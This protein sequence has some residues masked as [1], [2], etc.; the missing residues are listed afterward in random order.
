MSTQVFLELTQILDFELFIN[1]GLTQSMDIKTYVNPKKPLS[2]YV[3]FEL[4]QVLDLQLFINIAKVQ[5]MDMKTY[6]NS[7]KTY[8]N[9]DF[10]R[11]DVGWVLVLYFQLFLGIGQA[12]D[13]DIKAYVH[14]QKT[15]I[16]IGFGFS[17]DY[18]CMTG[19]RCEYQNLG[20]FQ[21]TYI[22]RGFLGIDISFN[23]LLTY[24]AK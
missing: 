4:A 16:D 24:I 22:N 5:G 17:S 3:F 14:S 1:I 12:Q 20:Q 6:I 23:C 7:K 18:Q 2:T 15:Y 9:I 11:I 13:M 21:K 8:V 10:W 19:T